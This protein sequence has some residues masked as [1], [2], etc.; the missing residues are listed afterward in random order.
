M[1]HVTI[2]EIQKLA[3]LSRIHL[4]DDEART[5]QQEIAHILDYVEKLNDVNTDGVVETAQVTGLENVMRE[6]VLSDKKNGAY[7]VS[8]EMLLSNVPETENGYI[9]VRRVL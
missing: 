7:G 3:R 9:K 1:A 8:Q 5:Y 6:D 2:D 4:T